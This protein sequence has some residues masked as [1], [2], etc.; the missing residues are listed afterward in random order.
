MQGEA[1][2]EACLCLLSG[3]L[4]GNRHRCRYDLLLSLGGILHRLQTGKQ[5]RSAITIT[6][7]VVYDALHA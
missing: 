1:C 3:L 4:Q 5:P 7:T 6:S 2:Y